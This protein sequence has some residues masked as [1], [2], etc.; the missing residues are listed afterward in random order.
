MAQYTYEQ[1]EAKYNG[2]RAP[3][4]KASINGS[5]LPAA[6]WRIES[7][8]C[9]TG[10]ELSAGI[11][12]VTLGG[13]YDRKN[14]RFLC[15]D[16]WPLGSIVEVELGYI[17]TESVFKGYLY[18]LE[19]ELG[20]EDPPRMILLCMDVKGA[21]MG[22]GRL[23]L[24]GGLTYRQAI[25][26]F[27]S[28]ENARGYNVLCDPPETDGLPELDNPIPFSPA[29]TDDYRFLCG[30]AQRFGL[31]FFVCKGKLLLRK[32][33]D[34][35][36]VLLELSSDRGIKRFHAALSSAGYIKSVTVRGGSD[37]ERDGEKKRALGKAENTQS[38]AAESS[39]AGRLI[40]QRSAEF[41]SSAGDDKA[42]Q[43]L[44]EAQMRRRREMASEISVRLTG[45]PELLPGFSVGLTR[46][47][48]KLDGN[49]YLTSVIHRMDETQF[50]TT[51]T[52]R[53]E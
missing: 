50:T 20:E 6:A 44:A 34:S 18:R 26:S 52:G 23:G 30:T 5:P 37:D 43:E 31:E 9:V 12:S 8:E 47:S 48:P 38:I 29:Q 46:F 22:N 16:E 39:D 40:G 21:M 32:K 14:S 1:L 15:E 19:Y 27:F 10:T 28:G 35:A 42:A 36:P 7:V 17:V 53:M 25:R 2:W 33:P 49:L 24:T 3:T 45:L 41:F 13:V 11:C 51:I 4:A